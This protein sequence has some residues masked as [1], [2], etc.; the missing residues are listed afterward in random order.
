[1]LKFTADF[2]L[3]PSG[4]LV[5]NH[6]LLIEESGI[7]RGL[8]EGV[9]IDSEYHEGILCP[10]FINTHCHLELSHLKN[11]IPKAKKL[12]GFISDIVQ[13]RKLQNH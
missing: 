10:G 12:H 1:M 11:I 7:I 5:D 3:H 4:Q 8:I 6:T 9:E 2:I 13:V